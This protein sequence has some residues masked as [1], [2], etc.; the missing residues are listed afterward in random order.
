MVLKSIKLWMENRPL[1][2][3]EV[4]MDEMNKIVIVKKRVEALVIE[5][6]VLSL[7]K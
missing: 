5:N 2:K 6:M 1:L 3:L 4:V 7:H